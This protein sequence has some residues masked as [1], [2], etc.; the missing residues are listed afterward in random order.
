MKNSTI[1]PHGHDPG[2]AL[3]YTPEQLPAWEHVATLP[4]ELGLRSHDPRAS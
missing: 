3:N 1:S 4:F 2:V